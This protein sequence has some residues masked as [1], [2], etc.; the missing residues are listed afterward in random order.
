MRRLL[1]RSA[2]VACALSLVAAESMGAVPKTVGAS[3]SAD[4]WTLAARVRAASAAAAAERNEIDAREKGLANW[5]VRWRNSCDTSWNDK[6][7]ETAVDGVT[8][9]ATGSVSPGLRPNYQEGGR[10]LIQRRDVAV[11]NALL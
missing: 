7:C 8:K 3:A 11:R 5:I 10:P 1:V 4:A 2:L 6:A 9:E